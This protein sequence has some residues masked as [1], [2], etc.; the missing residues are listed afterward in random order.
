MD[1][2]MENLAE[3]WW[4]C[5]TE[6]SLTNKKS[7]M[8]P[9]SFNIGEIFFRF[10]DAFRKFWYVSL[11]LVILGGLFGYF[12]YKRSYSPYYESKAIF[13]VKAANYDGDSKASNFNNR[14][15]TEDLSMSFN[16]LINNEVFYEI[17]KQD[18]KLDYVPA[19]ITITPIENTNI[20]NIVASG[21]DADLAYKTIKSVLKNYGSVTA[22]VVGDTKLSVIEEPTKAFEPANP[23]NPIISI[24]QYALVGL[25]ISMIP[26]I[27]IALFIKNIQTSEDI[28]KYLSIYPFGTLPFLPPEDKKAKV[29]VDCSILNKD[30]GFRYLESMR[31]VSSRCD[32][33]FKEEKTK[34]ILVTSTYSG[35][36]KSTVSMNLA[37]S[38]SK[39]QYKVMLIDGDLRKPSLKNMVHSDTPSF[40]MGEFLDG[41]VKSSQAIVN[42]KDTRV[43]AITP[44]QRTEHPVDV[45]NS[46]AMKT[47]MA[48]VKEVVDYVIIDAPPCTG[49]SD[50]AALA[51]YCD[52]VVYVLKEARSRVNKIINTLQEFSYT[53][54][55]VLGCILNGSYESSK[56]I[57]GYG[58]YSYGRYGYGIRRRGYGSGQYGMYGY[59]YGDSPRAKYG[60]G[61]YGYGKYG[62]FG[63][64]GY[65]ERYGYGDER[66]GYG[67]EDAYGEYGKTTEK[68]F[69]S[70]EHKLT[71][72]IKLSSTEEDRKNVEEERIKDE[73]LEEEQRNNPPTRKEI[74]KAEKEFR[75]QL[76]E[77]EKQAKDES[78]T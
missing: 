71:R 50:T 53:K 18:M 78:D 29:K 44:D 24:L 42:L 27:I 74:R 34:V 57:Y 21:S 16:Y 49:L 25:F 3:R 41:K 12:S 63:K 55:P 36:G 7:R 47:F 62:V 33:V 60:Y 9:D 26:S 70:T 67:S 38:L 11:I 66:Y 15:L 65:G 31:S 73:Q 68:E 23:Y 52:G 22:F 45:I 51:Q 2:D 1:M 6:N 10:F 72:H 39:M 77:S 43:I 32:R 35:D 8:N 56:N 76:K 40:S 19:T 58:R 17:L 69:K 4:K 28:S 14:Q 37:Y 61:K 46:D 5:M 13:S 30:V 54:K 59:G 64:Y 75:K 20:M 48:D